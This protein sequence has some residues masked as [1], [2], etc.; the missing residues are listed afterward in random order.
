[1]RHRLRV[2]GRQR[3]RAGARLGAAGAAA[4]VAARRRRRRPRTQLLPPLRRPC[5]GVVTIHDLAF[6]TYPED[7]ASRTRWKYRTFTPRAARSAE[8]I[9]CVSEFT[10]DD[11]CRRYD[12]DRTRTRIVPE[13]P[14]LPIGDSTPPDGPY[15]LAVGDLRRKK[16]VRALAAAFRSLHD[17]G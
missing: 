14:A 8:R 2:P 7:F 11:V 17:G 1:R 4:R 15:L 6:E 3:S 13:A 10:R 12:I 5:P 16:N 9:I